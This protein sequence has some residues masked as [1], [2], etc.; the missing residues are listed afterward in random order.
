MKLSRFMPVVVGLA[1]PSHLLALGGVPSR[2]ASGDLFAAQES[3]KVPAVPDRGG[4]VTNGFRVFIEAQ[5]APFPE[6][7]PITVVFHVKNVGTTCRGLAHPYA[8]YYGFPAYVRTR[9]G[10]PVKPFKQVG[11]AQGWPG[12][13]EPGQEYA[14]IGDLGELDS[15]SPGT[16]L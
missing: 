13:I 9:S 8:W 10:R 2:A 12:W 15:L 4:P 6:G 1:L 16:Y 11:P 5:R 14:E 7:G 3:A